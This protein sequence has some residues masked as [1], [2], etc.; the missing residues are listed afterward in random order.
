M[1]SWK[2]TPAGM[3]RTSTST[4]SMKIEH[5]LVIDKPAGLVVRG[6]RH[7]RTAPYLD[8]LLHALYPPGIAE[9]PRAGM[10]H[11]L[12]KDTTGLM[13][14]CQDDPG[15]DPSGGEALR[16]RQITRECEGRRHRSHD[17][18]RVL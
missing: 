13:V 11:R 7:A 2:M 18:R 9:V 15:P 6:R 16:A 4:S 3:P 10:V 8:A 12:D 17:R 1:S 14:V 5:I